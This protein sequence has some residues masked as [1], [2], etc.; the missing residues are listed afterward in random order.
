MHPGYAVA[1]Y[2]Q[3]PGRSRPFHSRNW[4]GQQNRQ[5]D[6]LQRQV[7]RLENDLRRYQKQPGPLAI[8]H[9]TNLTEDGMMNIMMN[10]LVLPSTI[11]AQC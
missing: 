2:D 1:A 8:V 3:P 11:N 6:Q 10:T 9:M 5:I 4:Q 7:T